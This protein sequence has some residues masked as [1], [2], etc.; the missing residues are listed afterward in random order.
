ME[1]RWKELAKVKVSLANKFWTSEV[2]QKARKLAQ[3][4]QQRLLDV[5]M[6]GLCN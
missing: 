3:P 2:G 5:L 4:D 6:G 1:D